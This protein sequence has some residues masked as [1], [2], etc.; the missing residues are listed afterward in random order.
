MLAIDLNFWQNM[1]LTLLSDSYYHFL[2]KNSPIVLQVEF[3]ILVWKICNAACFVLQE[4]RV[5]WIF[6]NPSADCWFCLFSLL[7]VEHIFA[8]DVC[9]CFA[10]K[11]RIWLL[12]S[13]STTCFL[14]FNTTSMG[15][16]IASSKCF[17]ILGVALANQG[18]EFTHMSTR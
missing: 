1:S 8:L 11:N 7:F 14:D 9:M 17:L 5:I 6:L 13:N 10:K 2:S 3:E 12:C 4:I 18:N 15:E 16:I